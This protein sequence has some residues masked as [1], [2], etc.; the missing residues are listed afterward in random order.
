MKALKLSDQTHAK[1]TSIV[2]QL[3]AQTG[4]IQTY[5]DATKV[6]L[7]RTAPLPLELLMEIEGFIDKN[8]QFGYTTK[9]DFV[10]DAI[11]FRIEYLTKQKQLQDEK[12][13]NE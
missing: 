4:K 13:N 11:R 9:E 1:L 8:K 3:T 10:V 6:L 12:I 5:E 7:Q 2:G